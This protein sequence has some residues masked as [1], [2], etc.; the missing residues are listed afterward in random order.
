VDA[1]EDAVSRFCN[2]CQREELIIAAFLGGSLAAGIADEVSDVDIYTITHEVDYPAFFARREVFMRSWARP[3]LLIDTLN[4]EGLGFD[5]VHFVLDDGVHGEL[6][7][8]H[9]GNFRMLHGGPHR[10]LIDKVGLLDG[11]TFPLHVPTA[12]ERRRQTARALS[13]F[14]LDFIQL[15]KHLHRQHRLAVAAQ[16]A[17]L[18]THCVELLVVARTQNVTVD[19]QVLSDRL[20][21]T[22]GMSDPA[23]AARAI[24]QL[25]QELGSRLAIHFGLPYPADVATLLSQR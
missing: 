5:M 18:R 19:V 25:H 21:A 11:V 16:L 9:S 8:G 4:F 17:R 24:A 1:H 14:W 2:A 23:A 12:A 10:A 3:L 7:L 6:A 15:H 22:V 13:W 20:A